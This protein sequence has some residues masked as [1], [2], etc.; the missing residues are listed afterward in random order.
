MPTGLLLCL[1][2]VSVVSLWL[3]LHIWRGRPTNPRRPAPPAGRRGCRR[4]TLHRQRA[5]ATI[6]GW[7]LRVVTRSSGLC[8]FFADTAP[9]YRGPRLPVNLGLRRI[10]APSRVCV[11]TKFSNP[12]PS[13]KTGTPYP[14]KSG[15]MGHPPEWKGETDSK[16]SR[17][18]FPLCHEFVNDLSFAP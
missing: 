17:R 8:L 5:M 18:H 3:S 4:A 7:L 13:T 14:R 12:H 2:L 1:I 11:R 6:A 15:G 16:F 10:T 9:G